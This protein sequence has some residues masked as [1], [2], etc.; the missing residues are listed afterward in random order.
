MRYVVLGFCVFAAACAELPRAP[1]SPSSSSTDGAAVTQARRGSELPFQGTLQAT[2]TADGAQRH[3]VGTGE[4]TH[5]G[6]FTLTSEF[7]VTS[8]PSTA[9]GIATWT[10]ANGDEIFTTLVGQGVVTF[11]ILSVVETHTI[12]GGT[13]RFAGTAGSIIVERSLNLQTRISSASI[14]GTI[15]LALGP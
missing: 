2:E 1:T 7:T 11:P 10:A 9:S 13:G 15:S 3:L 12:T 8:P 6:R 14:T 4:A 5:L